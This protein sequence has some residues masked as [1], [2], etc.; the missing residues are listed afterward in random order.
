MKQKL[1][2]QRAKRL[3]RSL[4]AQVEPSVQLE[5]NINSD[6]ALATTTLDH[7]ERRGECNVPKR[8]LKDA[9]WCEDRPLGKGYYI[10]DSDNPS[11]LIAV[12]FNFKHLQWG[13][14]HQQGDN[15]VVKR[16]APA[17]Y[18][19]RI[20]DKERTQDRSQWGPLDGSPDEDEAPN[21][22][23]KFGSE[24]GGDT[25][26]PDVV[27]PQFPE[28]ENRIAAIA[29]LIPSHISKPPIQPRSLVG[30]MAQIASTTTLTDSL[31]ARTLGTG[32]SQRGNTTSAEGILRTLFPTQHGRGDGG[33]DDPP[34]PHQ[35]DT[36]KRK[37]GG[38][39]GGGGGDDPGNGGGGGGG[40]GGPDP[41]GGANAADPG[42]LSDKMIGKEPEIF[43]GDRDKV[44]EFMTSWSVYQGIN[45]QTR[46]MNNPMSQTMLFFGYLRGPKMHLWIK[47]ISAQ[48]D[49]H[50][51]TG[52]RD[53]DEWIWET[54]I[55]DFAQNFQD[56]M[57]RERA[58]KKLFELK[59]ERGELDKYTSQF[60]Q[61]AE[62]A[63]YHELTG[64]ICRK[65]FQGLPQ[66]LQESMLAFEPTCHYQTLEDWIEG[67]IRQHSKYLTYQ[68]YFGGQKKFNPRNPNQRP[69]RQQWQ[70]GFAKNPNAMDLTPGRTRARAALT[71]DERA[72][73]RQEGKC[74]KCRKKG[75]MSRDCPDRASQAQSGTTKEEPQEEV[76]KEDAQIKQVTAEELVHL[77]RNMSQEE[78]DKVI[79]DVFMK[80]F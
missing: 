78:K 15:L 58:K 10:A 47:K 24:A 13:C 28:E 80:D 7:L 40:G 39:G 59:M 22:Q 27:I 21:P 36:G 74:F 68:A 60:Q 38:S 52:G 73:L 50:L 51:R 55:N 70:Q 12:D 64:M 61:L 30:A 9:D 43:T 25:P 1:H 6:F 32:V 49:R 56:V 65:Y 2:S 34:K 75:H 23:F 53:T 19:L 72:T 41:A 62:L 35:R 44:E 14:T 33:G 45:K 66:G 8:Y 79:Q 3:G 31:V 63:G 18:G 17:R 57:S 37:E 4:P 16:P 5:R 76:K 69:T 54:M 77:V 71:N 11:I 20:F 67:A 48:L 46:V 29:Q 42:A 26:D